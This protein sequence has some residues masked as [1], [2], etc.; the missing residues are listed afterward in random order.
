[1]LSRLIWGARPS[2]A[3]GLLAVAIG[4]LGGVTIG[5]TSAVI[6]GL[7]EQVAMRCMDGL[8]SIPPV[9]D[10]GHRHRRH[11]RCRPGRVPAGWSFP[12]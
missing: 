7:W 3:V 12:Q 5:L 11:R 8:A 4:T 6:R 9:A 2:L 10:L 1:M